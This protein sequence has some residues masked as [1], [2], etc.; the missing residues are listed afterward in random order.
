MTLPH[1]QWSEGE[2][3]EELDKVGGIGGSHDGQ[4]QGGDGPEAVK[5]DPTVKS[6]GGS[7]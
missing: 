1:F 4:R 7:E 5:S 6:K 3:R 2:R